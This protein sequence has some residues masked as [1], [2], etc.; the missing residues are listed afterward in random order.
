MRGRFET[1]RTG[2]GYKFSDIFRLDIQTAQTV[3][4]QGIG[5]SSEIRHKSHG[6]LS[7]LQKSLQRR[8]ERVQSD[9]SDDRIALSDPRFVCN[10]GH[11][12]T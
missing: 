9:A 7:H 11:F 3:S 2:F 8:Y 1:A 10:F 5:S 4:G 12:A 6:T